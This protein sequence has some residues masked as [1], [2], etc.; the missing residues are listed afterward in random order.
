M[1]TVFWVL[2]VVLCAAV[3]A[4]AVLYVLAQRDNGGPCPR[5]LALKTAAATGYLFAAGSAVAV[6]GRPNAYVTGILIALG[7]CW[8]GDFFLHLWQRQIYFVIG[9]LG[10]LGAHLVLIPTFVRETPDAALLT[11]PEA[12]CILGINVFVFFFSKRIGTKFEGWLQIP[13]F[14]Y[15]TILSTMLC[16]AVIFGKAL[17]LEGIPMRAC[18]VILGAA[19]FLCSDFSLAILLF[20]EKYKKNLR[21]NLFM[22]ITYF[23]AVLLFAASIF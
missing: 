21:L 16:K 5:S 13:I 3:L 7:L 23:S 11:L 22:A 17:F 14:L 10:F 20:N 6:T 4:L 19:L 18:F 9:F 15:C 8:I 12:L 1:D 2:F